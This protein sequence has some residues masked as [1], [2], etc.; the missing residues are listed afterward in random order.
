MSMYAW[1]AL[2]VIVIPLAGLAVTTL[3]DR[4]AVVAGTRDRGIEGSRGMG[5][6]LH[7]C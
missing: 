1:A 6:E 2:L 3:A 4:I 7:T 5:R